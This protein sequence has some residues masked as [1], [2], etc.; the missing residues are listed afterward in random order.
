MA[1]ALIVEQ[2]AIVADANTYVDADMVDAYMDNLGRLPWVD[3]ANKT[4]LIYRSALEMEA[5]YRTL[6]KG[7]K[8]DDNDAVSPQPL[9]WPRKE[10]T[11]EDGT[12]VDDASV[13]NLVQLAQMEIVWLISSGSEFVQQ[14]IT[15]EEGRIKSE[16]VGPL[17]TEFFEN[18]S[19]Q[20]IFPFIDQL[21]EPLTG[22]VPLVK[23]GANISLTTDEIR[24]IERQ[25]Q[26]RV[27]PYD[28][29]WDEFFDR[30]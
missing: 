27:N 10:V 1:V 23:L 5:R 8:R 19:T 12:L 30:Y 7:A 24:S 6:W 28:P 21:L 2:G 16:Q 20:S 3:V 18:K 15:S 9:S 4:A 13:P 11:D 14:E 22:G 26:F 29:R 17:K 25:E